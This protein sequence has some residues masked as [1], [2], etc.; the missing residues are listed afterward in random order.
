MLLLLLSISV[1]AFDF[2]SDGIYYDITSSTELTV[3]VTRNEKY[4]GDITIPSSVEYNGQKYSVTGIGE[5]AFASCSGLTN[6]T[7]DAIT[8]P[9]ISFSAFFMIDVSNVTLYVPDTAVETYK[10]TRY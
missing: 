7:C 1:S 8:P 6:I 10:A 5:S 2:E 9:S 3:E 4:S